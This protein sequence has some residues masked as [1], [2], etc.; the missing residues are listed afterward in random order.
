MK[1]LDPLWLLNHY[2]MLDINRDGNN[3][4][5]LSRYAGMGSHRYPI[6]FSGDTVVCWKSLDFQPYFTALASNAGYTWWSHDI[7]GHMFGKG[8]NELYLRWLQF[9]VFSPI[10]RLHSSNK[11]MSKEPWNYPQVENIAEDFCACAID[12]CR[13]CTP[14]TSTPQQRACRSFARRTTIVKTAAH[15]TKSGKISIISA[16]KCMFAPSR[17]RAKTALPS[18]QSGFPT[19]CGSTFY[20]RKIRG[21]KGIYDRVPV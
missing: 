11:G 15:T 14:Q 8:D 21:R 2:H 4:V 6:G 3:S 16:N 17:A 9:G 7:G 13:I 1:G 20:G 18:K 19:E 10:N 12:F 5:I